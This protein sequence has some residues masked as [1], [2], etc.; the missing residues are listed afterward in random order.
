MKILKIYIDEQLLIKHYVKKHLILLKIQNMMDIQ[1]DLL[2]WP[3]NFLIKKLQVETV[4]N[5]ITSNKELA[6]E[7]HKLLQDLIKEKYTHLL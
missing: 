2:Q 5:K 4:Q 3:I 1:V 6:E 7:L